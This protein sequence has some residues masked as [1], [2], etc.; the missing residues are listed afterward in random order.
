MHSMLLPQIIQSQ[1]TMKL[2]LNQ[3]KL[4]GRPSKC[5]ASAHKVA[6]T[7]QHTS[8]PQDVSAEIRNAFLNSWLVFQLSHFCKTSREDAA[9]L[10]A[11]SHLQLRLICR[12]CELPMS[13]LSL[14]CFSTET[15]PTPAQ[16]P[17]TASRALSI[18][19]L[20]K[21]HCRPTEAQ[22]APEEELSLF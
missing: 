13:S 19:V 14:L 16:P 7:T 18:D 5:P 2:E 15:A 4:L 21:R 12:D 8:Q 10:C 11:S 6:G 3:S 22:P 20:V 17:A 1:M 9:C